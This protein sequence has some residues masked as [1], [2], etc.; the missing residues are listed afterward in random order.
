MNEND[1]LLLKTLNI[2]NVQVTGDTRFDRVLENYNNHKSDKEIKKNFKNSKN[3]VIGS[4]WRE[5][6]KILLIVATIIH[7]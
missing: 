2:S 4:S 5:D 7:P 3:F 6:H 1:K